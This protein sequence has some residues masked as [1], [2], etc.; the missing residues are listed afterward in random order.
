MYLNPNE[1]L[2]VVYIVNITMSYHLTLLLY[3]IDEYYG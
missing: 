2:V 1:V 3:T